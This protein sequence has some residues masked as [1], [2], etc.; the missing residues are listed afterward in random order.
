MLRTVLL[1]KKGVT[2]VEVMIA[3]VIL[4][5]VSLALMQTALVSINANMNNVLRDEAVSIAEQR[6]NEARNLPYALIVSDSTTIPTPNDCPTTFTVG[7]QF[8]LDT[9]VPGSF[10]S[11]VKRSFRNIINK[12]Y[13]T[14]MTVTTLGAAGDARQVSIQVIWNWKGEAFSHTITTLIRRPS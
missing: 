4:L 3:L 10:D 12:D 5:L 1:N 11:P 2:L 7:P 9:A 14:N 13:C 8:P 6:L